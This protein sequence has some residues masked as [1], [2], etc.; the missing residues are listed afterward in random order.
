[1]IHGREDPLVPFACGEVTARAVPGAELVAIDGMGHDI[2]PEAWP[3]IAG[4]IDRN[5]RRA[6]GDSLS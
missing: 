5:A 6:G 2:P 4:A 1:V 3:R